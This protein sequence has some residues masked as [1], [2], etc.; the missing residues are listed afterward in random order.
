MLP[1]PVVSACCG[2]GNPEHA[3][4]IFGDPPDRTCLKGPDATRYIE[5]NRLP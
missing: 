5:A 1:A 2:H 4:V 3:S